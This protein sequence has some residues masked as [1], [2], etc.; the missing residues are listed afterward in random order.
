MAVQAG[1]VFVE[2]GARLDRREFEAYDREL[3]KVREKTPKREHFKA[4]LGADYDAKAFNA[5]QRDLDRAKRQN[6]DMVKANGRLRTSFGSVW[7]RGGA[8]FAAA[9]GAFAV[10]SAVKSVTSAYSDSQVSQEKMRAQL[11]A[12][13]ID[14]D[15][16][17]KQIDAV[18]Q[19]T[20]KLAG[21]DD[22]DLQDAFTA[23]APSSKSV[24]TGLKDMSLV[25]DLARA[26]HLDVAK[27]GELVAK[28]H[29]GNVGALR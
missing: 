13:G 24:N 17:A 6:D 8:A 26:K 7:S 19:R 1:S 3:K 2:L 18:I 16:H 29:T 14:Y 5:Y 23:V 15:A 28:V 21:L 12:L 4:Q 22:E 27:A 25:A 11:K 20:S 9:G 10:V